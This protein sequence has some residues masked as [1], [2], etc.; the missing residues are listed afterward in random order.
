MKLQSGSFVSGGFLDWHV[1][2]PISASLKQRG[3]YYF[4]DT[5]TYTRMARLIKWNT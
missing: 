1:I 3:W 2:W 5:P 4:Y